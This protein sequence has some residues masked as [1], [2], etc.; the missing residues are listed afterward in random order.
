LP[1]VVAFKDYHVAV[2]HSLSKPKSKP[3]PFF[4]L[5]IKIEIVIEGE[6]VEGEVLLAGFEVILIR[7]VN[8]V[9]LRDQN[10]IKNFAE[11][12]VVV[13]RINRLN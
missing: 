1:L 4:Y 13:V 12:E 7:C 9:N 2:S 11:R 8:Y 6:H 10:L 3:R 5:H